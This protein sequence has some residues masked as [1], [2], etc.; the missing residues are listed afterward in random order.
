VNSM[1]LP[2]TERDELVW[3]QMCVELWEDNSVENMLNERA[4][5]ELE[6]EFLYYLADEAVAFLSLSLR[7]DY[8]EGTDS[9]PVGYI[10]G[11]YVREAYRHK[12]IAKELIEFAKEWSSE[13]GC[14]ELASDCVIT[15]EDSRKFHNNVG[16]KEANTIVCFTMEI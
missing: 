15:N 7:Y 8:V 12:G 14:S 4:D 11:I 6:N 9:S 13:R 10:E 2:V 1:I 16:F 3:A 5:G